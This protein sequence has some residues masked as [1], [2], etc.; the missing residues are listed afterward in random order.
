M[1]ITR[2]APSPTGYVHVGTIRTLYFNYLFARSQNGKLILRIDDTDVERSEQKFTDVIYETISKLNIEFDLTFKQSE[3]LDRY[4]EISESLI[5]KDQAKRNED[6]SISFIYNGDDIYQWEDFVGG[7]IKCSKQ[8]NLI[9][10]EFVIIRNNGLPTYNF[11]TVVDDID[12]NISHIIRGTDH[13]PNTLKQIF[14]YTALTDSLP[15]FG[16]IGLLTKNGKK[17]SKRDKEADFLLLLNEYK[18]EAILNYILK[19]GW[20]LPDPNIDQKLPLI[21]KQKAIEVFMNGKMKSS[22]SNVDM[23]KLTWLNKKY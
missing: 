9:S 23:N 5:S 22:P 8:E 17:I 7:N 21:N 11:A 19:L 2:C 18:P 15:K 14:L 1:I 13:I 10:R 16:H 4:K 3:R 20:N 12:Y 6:N